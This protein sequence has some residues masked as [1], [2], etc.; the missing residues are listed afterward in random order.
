MK[1]NP[2]KTK[3]PVIS[4]GSR[5]LGTHRELL[6]YEHKG[7]LFF[8]QSHLKNTLDMNTIKNKEQDNMAKFIVSTVKQYLNQVKIISIGIPINIDLV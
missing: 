1:N 2:G 8:D 3:I 4:G 7:K 5:P 6:I